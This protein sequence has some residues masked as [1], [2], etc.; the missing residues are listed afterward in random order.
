MDLL[1]WEFCI[2]V[3]PSPEA[4]RV[5]LHN[6]KK[7]FWLSSCVWSCCLVDLSLVY[8]FLIFCHGINDACYFYCIFCYTQNTAPVKAFPSICTQSNLHGKVL[9]QQKVGFV[10]LIK[11][12]LLHPSFP[13]L[14]L[15]LQ[16]MFERLFSRCQGEVYDHEM[17]RLLLLNEANWSR[18]VT[19]WST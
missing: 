8:V 3:C 12:I 10:F 6:S 17:G 13:Q 5:S 16:Q 15:E 1:D 14:P 2:S 19:P 4:G 9:C 11:Y 7:F 18:N